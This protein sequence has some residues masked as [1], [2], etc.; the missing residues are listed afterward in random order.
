MEKIIYSVTRLTKSGSVKTTG[1]GVID[2]ADLAVACVNKKGSAYIRVYPGMAKAC[3][4]VVGTEDQYKGFYSELREAE[5]TDENGAS[6]KKEV[7]T[8]YVVWYKVLG[9]EESAELAN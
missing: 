9:E 6:I 3:S 4:K 7:V 5:F 8:D 2:G 1:I